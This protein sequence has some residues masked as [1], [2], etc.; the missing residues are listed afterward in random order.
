M[1]GSIP[2]EAPV[3]LED[4]HRRLLAYI[5]EHGSISQREY[6]G[7]SNRSLAAR[8]QDFRKLVTLG[9]IV[10]KGGG[11]KKVCVR[12]AVSRGTGV[13]GTRD[14]G[15]DCGKFLIVG[16]INIRCFR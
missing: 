1:R 4:H 14:G 2:A 8:K 7:T 10:R 3:R 15:L 11:A 6:G 16:A 12:P 5:S 13:F 9:M